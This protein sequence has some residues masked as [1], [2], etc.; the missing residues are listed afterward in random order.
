MAFDDSYL[1]NAAKR[2]EE[3]RWHARSPI[4]GEP[5]WLVVVDLGKKQDPTVVQVWKYAV[6]IEEGSA[7]MNRPTRVSTSL[8]LKRCYKLQNEEYA[9]SRA[10]VRRL[11]TSPR[12]DNNHRLLVDS[13][14]VG[15]SVVEDMR[16]DGLNPIAIVFTN[17]QGWSTKYKDYDGRFGGRSRLKTL[18]IIESFN[19][20]KPEMVTTAVQLLQEGRIA[21]SDVINPDP[22]MNRV[23]KDDIRKQLMGFRGKVNELT[24]NVAYENLTDDIHDDMVV[25]ILMAAWWCVTYTPERSIELDKLVYRGSLTGKGYG[26]YGYGPYGNESGASYDFRALEDI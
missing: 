20:G 17:A 21:I 8:V 12:L 23:L 14:G 1:V 25:C 10:V 24:K 15:I 3:E 9:K 6:S 4:G 7:V 26:S 22:A 11:C 19:V 2:E 5:E 18:R 13:T 16:H